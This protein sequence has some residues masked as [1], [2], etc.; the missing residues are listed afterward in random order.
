MFCGGGGLF[1]CFWFDGG[2]V[3]LVGVGFVLVVVVLVYCVVVGY[4]GVGGV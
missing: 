3:G 4:V 2:G 1:W